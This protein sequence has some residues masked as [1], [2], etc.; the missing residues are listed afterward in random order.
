ML[1]SRHL[2][3][4]FGRHLSEGN[5]LSSADL[6]ILSTDTD[7]GTITVVGRFGDKHEILKQIRVGNAPR[8]SV[9]FTSTGRGFVS[10]TSQNTVSEIDPVGLSEV[11]RIEVG[12]GPRGLGVVPGDRYLLVSNSGSDTISVVDLDA[13]V[14]LHQIACG[15][16][17]RHMAITSDG[18]TAF[19]SI[20]GDGHIA[21]LDLRPLAEDRVSDVSI[22]RT[23]DVGATAHPY[24]VS[25]AP[26]EQQLFVANTQAKYV[27]VIDVDTN[28]ETRVEVAAIGGRAV[29]YS[30]DGGYALVTIETIS[31]L[32]VISLASL[33]VTRYIETGPGPRGLAVDKPSHVVYVSAFDRATL[34]PGTEISDYGPN[35]LTMVDLSTG[36]LGSAVGS[37]ESQ[38]V[39]VGYGPCSVSLFEPASVAARADALEEIQV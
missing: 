18:A 2:D 8:G 21:R 13:N 32:A 15:R 27:S 3:V 37:F 5:L 17:P 38:V 6:H 16:D 23:I 29:G 10:N 9:K 7:D 36:D 14:E 24:S 4:S 22:E 19:V 30:P 25:F 28:E 35:T 26:G 1:T 33:E 31:K 20:W 39:P 12:H 11:R 34:M